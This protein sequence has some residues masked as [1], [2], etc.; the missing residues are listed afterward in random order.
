MSAIEFTQ[1]L[2]NKMNEI[3][4]V[5]VSPTPQYVPPDDEIYGYVVLN[6]FEW[7]DAFISRENGEISD[8][9]QPPYSSSGMITLFIPAMNQGLLGTGWNYETL[10]EYCDIWSSKSILKKLNNDRSMGGTC[11]GFQANSATIE[12]VIDDDP[13]YSTGYVWSLQIEFQA[14]IS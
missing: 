12:S 9:N 6:Y 4:G 10:L 11:S 14:F 7:P 13:E 2:A 1:A 3:T 8:R 5:T